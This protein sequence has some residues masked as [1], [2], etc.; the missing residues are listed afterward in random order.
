[1]TR[2]LIWLFYTKIRHP[3]TS[4]AAKGQYVT[5]PVFP[6]RKLLLSKYLETNTHKQVRQ[7]L[8]MQRS[9]ALHQGYL[10]PLK[11]FDET[12]AQRIRMIYK[13]LPTADWNRCCTWLKTSG[14]TRSCVISSIPAVRLLV[15]LFDWSPHTSVIRSFP[16]L[17]W[18][19]FDHQWS[20]IP[21]TSV[22]FSSMWPIFGTLIQPETPTLSRHRLRS[23]PL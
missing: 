16:R 19:Y 3:A 2:T 15:N 7:I 4:Y 17:S 11:C 22:P 8:Q 9:S 13:K 10:E 14:R 12:V 5:E 20:M 1:M 6:M 23:P 18:E 21:L